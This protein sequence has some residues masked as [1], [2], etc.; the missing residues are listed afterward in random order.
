MSEIG[1]V[2]IVIKPSKVK[3]S[4]LW[5]WDVEEKI[6]DR[7]H[8]GYIYNDSGQQF[9]GG[10]ADDKFLGIEAARKRAKEY[11]EARKQYPHAI[12]TEILKKLTYTEEINV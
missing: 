6:N 9:Y 8:M 3:G 1:K 4:N 5:H 10:V 7:W 2:R 12:H 11:I